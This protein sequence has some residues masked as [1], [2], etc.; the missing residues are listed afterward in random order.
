MSKKKDSKGPIISAAIGA[1]FFAVPYVAL[2]IPLLPSIGIAAVAFGAGNLIFS[3]EKNNEIIGEFDLSKDISKVINQAKKQNSQIE[4][5]IKKIN[6]L[7]LR[8][9][10]K[11]ITETASKIIDTVENNP[12]KYD[13]AKNFFGYY[14]PV[15]LKIITEYDN[16][17]NQGLN[18]NEVKKFMS[19]AENMISKINKSF[20]VQL[21][22]LYQTNIIDTDAEMKVFESML[23]LDGFDDNDFNIKGGE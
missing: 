7:E 16:I 15:T 22:N 13:K 2:S 6:S 9:K 4:L 23:N 18:N 21:T 8:E 20:K 14:L 19:S 11:E 12:E 3:S 10:I 17:E 1:T 5:L